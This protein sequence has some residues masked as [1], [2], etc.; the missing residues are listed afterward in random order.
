MSYA[1]VAWK[2]KLGSEKDIKNPSA[3]N[4]ILK[5]RC[6]YDTGEALAAGAKR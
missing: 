3:V 5:S 1:V 6:A 4:G 2:Y